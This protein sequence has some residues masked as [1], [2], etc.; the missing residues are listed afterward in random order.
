[1]LGWLGC[2]LESGENQSLYL[3]FAT[4]LAQGV[5]TAADCPELSTEV[6]LELEDYLGGFFFTN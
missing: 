3:V 1:M 2:Q 5:H 6:R 4:R